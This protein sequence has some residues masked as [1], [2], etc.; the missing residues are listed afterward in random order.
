MLK[1]ACNAGIS[2]GQ[3]RNSRHVKLSTGF[4]LALLMTLQQDL[5]IKDRLTADGLLAHLPRKEKV[6]GK[7]QKF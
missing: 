2:L 3:C 6:H 5:C 1:N 4:G 7:Q